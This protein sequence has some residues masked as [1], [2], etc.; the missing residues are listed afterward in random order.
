VLGQDRAVIVILAIFQR[1]GELVFV[2]AGISIPVFPIIFI[3]HDL[4]MMA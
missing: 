1:L 2:V 3:T 4:G